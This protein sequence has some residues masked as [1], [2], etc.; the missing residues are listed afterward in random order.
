MRWSIFL[1]ACAIASV[2]VADV[3]RPLQ[4]PDLGALILQHRANE[5]AIALG[6]L[7]GVHG[8]ERVRVLGRHIASELGFVDRQVLALARAGGG[9]MMTPEDA[10]DRAAENRLVIIAKLDGLAFDRAVIA[11]LGDEL[12]LDLEWMDSTRIAPHDGTVLTLLAT[13]RPSLASYRA[14]IDW[15]DRVMRPAS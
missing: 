5:R 6:R 13:I 11:A 15:L 4:P 3:P 14:E 1:C 9:S 10:H 12:Q 8:S 2:A 7:A